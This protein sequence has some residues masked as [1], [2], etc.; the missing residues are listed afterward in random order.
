VATKPVPGNQ[1]SHSMHINRGVTCAKCHADTGHHVTF[2]SLDQAGVLNKQNAPSGSTYV[3]QEFAGAPGAH[4]V[5]PGHRPVPCSNCHD[6]A[7]LQCSFC[8][9]PP[10]NHFGPDCKS[11]HKPNVA[12]QS[13]QH[14]PSGE[15]SYLSRPCVACHPNGYTTVYC[16]CHPGGQRPRGD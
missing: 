8:H 7:N 9:A 16:T 15:H 3:G 12:F 4:S 1:F 10:A 13:F 6:Q 5:L 14:P 2:A 11:C